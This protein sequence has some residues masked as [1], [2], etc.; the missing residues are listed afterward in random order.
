MRVTDREAVTVRDFDRTLNDLYRQH[1]PAEVMHFRTHL[2]RYSLKVA[3]GPFLTNPEDIQADE[4]L[5]TP[6]DVKLG[7]AHVHRAYSRPLHG[8]PHPGR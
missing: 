2:P 5:E 4:W 8:T 3:A 6:A 7:R 1:V